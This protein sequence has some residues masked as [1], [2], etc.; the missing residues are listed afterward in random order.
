MY[1]VVADFFFLFFFISFILFVSFVLFLFLVSL[2]E[3]NVPLTLG[4]YNRMIV[5]ATYTHAHTY[6]SRNT[7]T[8]ILLKI[9]CIAVT[10]SRQ[11]RANAKT[12]YEPNT[13]GGRKKNCTRRICNTEWKR[14]RRARQFRFAGMKR[15]GC[16]RCRCRTSTQR[17]IY[18]KR[19]R[20]NYF[21]QQL[22]GVSCFVCKLFFLSVFLSLKKKNLRFLFL[23]YVVFLA[24]T[25]HD[26]FSVCFGFCV[27]GRNKKKRILCST[28]NERKR[29]KNEETRSKS[30][31]ELRETKSCTIFLC[32]FFGV[33]FAWRL[34]TT[35][36][37][38]CDDAK[39]HFELK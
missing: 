27:S 9:A 19:T 5:H 8:Y 7:Q 21:H 13:S 33:S 18:N 37:L 31:T 11:R 3:Y 28:L 26:E 17:Y 20:R 16:L 36:L 2:C 15:H 12:H 4:T 22:F 1:I 25:L 38:G 35:I 39:L 29:R 32:F 6:E 30:E 10:R 23:V 34:L 24:L 14:E